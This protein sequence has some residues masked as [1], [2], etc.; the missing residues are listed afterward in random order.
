[1]PWMRLLRGK[2]SAVS[3]SRIMCASLLVIKASTFFSFS[4]LFC[5][6]LKK[7]VL[8]SAERIAA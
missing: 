8:S 6:T 2:L 5:F 1:V 3:N 7:A 4:H